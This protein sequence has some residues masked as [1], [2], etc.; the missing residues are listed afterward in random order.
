MKVNSNILEKYYNGFCTK[1]EEDIVEKWLTSSSFDDSDVLNLP[2]NEDKKAHKEKMWQH[3]S[4]N[5]EKPTTKVI[6]LYKKIIRYSAVAC[7]VLS[8][9]LFGAHKMNLLDTYLI[10]AN[11]TGDSKTTI[12]NGL[13]LGLANKS[14]ANIYSTLCNTTNQI[15]FCGN[16]TIKNTTG[17]NLKIKVQSI[18]NTDEVIEKVLR[19]NEKY[20]A[21]TLKDK[22]EEKL[23]VLN[24]DQ[25]IELP[26]HLLSKA[27]SLTRKI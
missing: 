20:Y 6:P 14:T 19:K 27:I 21:F 4:Q 22:K 10:L 5:L 26:R 17:S 16:M 2:E 9:G 8:I 13:E 11:N 25:V 7:V 18:C 24:K 23:Y 12:T 3:I 15:T 1:T